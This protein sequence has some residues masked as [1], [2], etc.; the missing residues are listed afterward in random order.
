MDFDDTEQES[1]FRAECRAWL[2]AN[3]EQKAQTLGD[4][5][6]VRDA[7]TIAASKAWQAKKADAGWAC[8]T[9]P[10]EYGGRA[11]SG[12]QNAIWNQEEAKYG[13]P[14]NLFYIGTGMLGPT[15]MTQRPDLEIVPLRGNVPTR[16]RKLES[17]DLD[18]VILACAGLDRLGLDEHIEERIAPEAM[19]PAVGQGA[20]A[21][22]VRRDDPIGRD[23][24]A[25]DDAATSIRVA[26]ERAFQIRLGGDCNAPLAAYAEWEGEVIHLRALIADPAGRRVFRAAAQGAGPEPH[27]QQGQRICLADQ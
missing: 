12:I 24:A 26:A 3:A 20:L 8:I 23:V 5:F 1:A 10:K 16:L 14:P 27:G 11:A 2:D 13:T 15:L 19:L 21:L 4:S 6:N 18:A 9:W 17:D 7:E 25:L 22:E